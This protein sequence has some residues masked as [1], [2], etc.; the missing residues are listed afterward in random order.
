[1]SLKSTRSKLEERNRYSGSNENTHKIRTVV[2]LSANAVIFLT[3]FAAQFAV[4][5]MRNK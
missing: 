5:R 4:A 2:K 3:Q 1:M